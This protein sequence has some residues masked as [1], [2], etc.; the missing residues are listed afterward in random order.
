MVFTVVWGIFGLGPEA[1][2]NDTDRMMAPAFADAGAPAHSD[3]SAAGQCPDSFRRITDMAGRH[4]LIPKKVSKVLSTSPPPVTFVY[5]LA[6][7]KLGGW[8]TS[9]SEEARK[10]IP[11]QYRDITVLSWGRK[12]NNYEAYIAQHPELVFVGYEMGTDSSRIDLI[13][14]KFGKIPVVCVDNTRDAAGYAETIRFIGDVLGVPQRAQDL[15]AYYQDVMDEVRR[16]VAII[17]KEKR[18]RVYYAEGDN[19]LS[20]DPSG[21]PHAQLID[22]CGGVNVAD[23]LISSGSGMTPVTIESVLMWQPDVIITTSREFMAHAQK[24]GTWKKITAVQNNRVYCAPRTPFNWFDRPP[25]VNR[26]VGIAWTA[27]ILYPEI[28]SREWLRIK[29][30]KFYALYYHHPLDDEAFVSLLGG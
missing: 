22:V 29:V 23:C 18:S 13:R 10:F 3:K 26:I 30:K 8:F 25:G 1:L 7:E 12:S 15:V 6:P 11:K 16:K 17:P 19:G 20:T 27:H 24:D 28:F 9:P 5:M 21:S 4:V 2:W 14:E